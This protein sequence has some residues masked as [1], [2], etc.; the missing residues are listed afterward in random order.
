MKKKF[1]SIFTLLIAILLGVA[2]VACEDYGKENEGEETTTKRTFTHTIK[3]GTFYDAST[4]STSTSG[5]M[6]VLDKVTDWTQ[7]SGS[8]TTSKTGADGVLSAVTKTLTEKNWTIT[9]RCPI[10]E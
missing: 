2:L 4:T 6:S 10:P 3:N 8:T 5:D 7:M 9:L 1:L